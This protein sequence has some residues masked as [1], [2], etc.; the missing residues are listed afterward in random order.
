MQGSFLMRWG[1]AFCT[2]S[3]LE[4]QEWKGFSHRSRGNYAAPSWVPTDVLQHLAF[5]LPLYF[6]HKERIHS[7]IVPQLHFTICKSKLE[8]AAVSK[9]I[10]PSCSKME[11]LWERL[12]Q[13]L[14]KER[15]WLPLPHPNMG[16][17]T[18]PYRAVFSPL[19]DLLC[20]RSS[21]WYI[22]DVI[23]KTDICK[24]AKGICFLP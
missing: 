13:P 23:I 1:S 18:K 9:E 15:C 7:K 19:N 4:A 11:H 12:W 6:V 3:P 22:S 17:G 5:V 2:R 21:G 16:S 24:L 20:S 10:C 8:V 14:P